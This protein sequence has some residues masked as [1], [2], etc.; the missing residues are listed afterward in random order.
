[1]AFA[2]VA[3]EYDDMMTKIDVDFLFGEKEKNTFS[4]IIIILIYFE[5]RKYPFQSLTT[6][7]VE[8]GG[9]TQTTSI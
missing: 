4:F 7:I 8:G 2:V 5:E 6:L 1:M 9:E 3:V